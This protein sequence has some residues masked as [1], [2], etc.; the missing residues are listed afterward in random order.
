MIACHIEEAGIGLLVMGAYGH[1]KLL[2]FIIDDGQGPFQPD[3][4]DSSQVGLKMEFG[5][6]KGKIVKT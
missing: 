4:G 1:S 3:F 6:R 2:I 5:H